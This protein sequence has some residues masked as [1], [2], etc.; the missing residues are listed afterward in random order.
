MDFNDMEHLALKILVK[1]DEAG[2]VVKTEVAKKY[3]E[4]LK[5]LR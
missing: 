5:R 4:K 1:K 3:E 2:N